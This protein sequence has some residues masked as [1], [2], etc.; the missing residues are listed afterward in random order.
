[1]SVESW[2][3]SSHHCPG[4]CRCH[5][6]RR[7]WQACFPALII[8]RECP[9]L[10]ISDQAPEGPATWLVL[11]SSTPASRMWTQVHTLFTSTVTWTRSRCSDSS[12]L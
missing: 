3:D 6:C 9:S 5:I 1:M 10:S 7:R 8:V 12:F 11:A 4:G 2:A